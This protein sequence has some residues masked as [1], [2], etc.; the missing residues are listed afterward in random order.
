M[1]ARGLTWRKSSYSNDTGGNCVE[2][3]VTWRK[4]TYSNSQNG[5]CVEVAD[6]AYG[7]AVRDTQHRDHGHLAFPACEWSSFL[8]DL[9]DRRL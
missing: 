6:T 5:N 8:K 4:S 9:K 3:A 7:A 2:M 1:T